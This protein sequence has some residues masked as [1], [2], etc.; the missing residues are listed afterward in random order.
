MMFIWLWFSVMTAWAGELEFGYSPSLGPGEQPMLS[1][2]VP[3]TVD[4]IW[5]Q[6]EAGGQS[7][8]FERSSMEAGEQFKVNWGRNPSVTEAVA[9]IRCEFSDGYVEAVQ[10]PVSYSYAGRLEVDLSRASADVQKRILTV[11][12]NQPIE[13][14]DITALGARKIVLDKRTVAIGDGPGSIDVPWIGDAAEVVLLDVTLHTTN[15]WAG[16]TYSPWFLD[17]PH[18]DVIF[19][20]GKWDIG[21]AEEPKLQ[22]LKNELDSVVDKYGSVVQVKLYIGGCTDTVGTAESNRTLSQNR[23]RS[24]GNWLSRNGVSIPI[25][26]YGFGESWLAVS[27]GDGVDNAGNRRAVYMVG[28]NPPPASAGVPAGRWSAL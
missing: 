22:V 1:V 14:A 2:T 5:I 10:V 19:E 18:D 16:F 9:T 23:A 27:T 25:F 13:R 28:A 17:I 24:I 3:R 11:D 20:T 6:I 12:V 15:A 7:W 4:L 21:P 8:D 26:Y